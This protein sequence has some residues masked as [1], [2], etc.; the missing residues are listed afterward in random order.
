[1][2]TFKYNAFISYSHSDEKWA[3]RL[4]KALETYSIP[5][6]LVGTET[7]HGVVPKRLSPI[8]RDRE[9]LPGA[10]DLGKAV[11]AALEQSANLIVICSPDAA[12]SRWVNEEILAYKRLGRYDRVFPII[13]DGEPHAS[14]HPERGLEECFPEALRFK[15]GPDGE[16]SDEPEEPIA[17]DARSGKDGTANARLKLVSGILG[18]G[19]DALKQRDHHR[20]QRRMA[21]ITVASLI[22]MVV[23]TGLAT[24]AW[25]ARAEAERQRVRAEAEAETARQTT[26]FLVGLFEVSDPGES[27]GREITAAELLE[28]GA[29]RIDVEL[30]DQPDVRATIKDTMGSVYT[31]LGDYKTASVFLRDSLSTR[32]SL[33]GREDVK[34]AQSLNRLGRVLML[35][36]E[37]EEAEARHRE[38]LQVRREMFGDRHV[39]VAQSMNDLADVLT[40]LGEYE[41]AETMFRDALALR[42]ELLGTQHPDVAQ[43]LEDLAVN[44]IRQGDYESAIPLMQEAI[45]IRVEVQGDP[46]HPDLAEALGNL[47]NALYDLGDYEES[48]RITRQALAM[49]RKSLPDIHPEIATQLNNLAFVLHDQGKYDEAETMYREVIA[50]RRELLGEYHPDFGSA[51]INLAYLLYDK[52]DMDGALRLSRYALEVYQHSYDGAEHPDIAMAQNNLALWLMETGAYDEAEIL[53][54]DA[55][56]MRRRLLGDDHP[57]IAGSMTLLADLLVAT[58]QFDEAYSYAAQ[59]RQISSGANTENHWRTAIAASAEGAALTGMQKYA[60]A[61]TLLLKSRDVLRADEGA[62]P[63]FV[64]ATDQRLASLYEDWGRPDEA[65]KYRSH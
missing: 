55:L 43:T 35:N 32:Q 7:N 52:G 17:A 22:G 9:E 11:N 36:A 27:R 20:R 15:V 2:S 46:P 30:A 45:D 18:V 1:M 14:D 58:K 44:R 57:D 41:T 60:E 48:E 24:A 50:M 65:A 26:D 49:Q 39:D 16:L 5:K 54:R 40:R 56:E 61:E 13:V 59:A 10:A 62:L 4:H 8:F 37:F 23:A 6:P 3:V 38:A 47:S 34:V 21:A 64:E 53:L 12:R 31:N 42:H 51:L 33:R 25:L 63:I 19:F 28:T 29:A